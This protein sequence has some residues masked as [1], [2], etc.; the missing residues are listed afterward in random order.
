MLESVVWGL[1]IIMLLYRM[2]LKCI[3]QILY[4]LQYLLKNNGKFKLASIFSMLWMIKWQKVIFL[5]LPDKL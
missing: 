1:I 3:Q 2:F 4:L 5:F